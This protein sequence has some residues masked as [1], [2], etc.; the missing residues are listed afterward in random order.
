MDYTFEDLKVWIVCE[1]DAE[2][3]MKIATVY[4]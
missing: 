4:W 3:E 1:N 2:L